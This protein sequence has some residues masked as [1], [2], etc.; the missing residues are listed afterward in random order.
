M[1]LN[2]LGDSTLR[3]EFA[4]G[5]RS[6]SSE[7]D[8]PNGWNAKVAPLIEGLAAWQPGGSL[9]ITETDLTLR[10]AAVGGY[11]ISAPE[12]VEVKVPAAALKSAHV[13]ST[14]PATFVIHASP[15]FAVEMSGSL[16]VGAQTANVTG[17]PDPAICPTL[18]GS[19][20]GEPGPWLADISIAAEKLTAPDEHKRFGALDIRVRGD[21][22]VP[23][24]GG[25]TEPMVSMPMAEG[26]G[27][28]W[29]RRAMGVA[30]ALLGFAVGAWL[31]GHRLQ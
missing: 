2:I 15:P 17:C 7:H 18:N 12:T 19:H 29:P 20:A 13:H 21:T 22:F 30:L 9:L 28:P 6:Y 4:R 31:G 11:A 27:S 3:K 14:A 25:D 1:R 5:I 10:I 24:V 26:G 16:F 8:E 23:A